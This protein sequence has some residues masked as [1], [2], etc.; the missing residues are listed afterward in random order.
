MVGGGGG[1]KSISSRNQQQFLTSFRVIIPSPIMGFKFIIAW[2]M[3]ETGLALDFNF[4]GNHSG[5][6]L[7]GLRIKEHI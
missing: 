4:I 2:K 7:G 6:L 5:P 1:V 3:D